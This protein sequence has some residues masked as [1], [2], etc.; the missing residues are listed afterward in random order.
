MSLKDWWQQILALR[1]RMPDP[2]VAEA[3]R[4]QRAV[5]GGS[6]RV[7]PRC[8]CRECRRDEQYATAA[9]LFERGL[10]GGAALAV[11]AAQSQDGVCRIVDEEAHHG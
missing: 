3:A 7:P 4:Q 8:A 1:G 10:L 6:V 2:R 9:R 11:I 5:T